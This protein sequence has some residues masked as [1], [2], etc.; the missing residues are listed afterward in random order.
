LQTRTR[1]FADAKFPLPHI[2]V[3]SSKESERPP[4]FL[5]AHFSQDFTAHGVSPVFFLD[6][7][8]SSLLESAVVLRA[9]A[10]KPMHDPM[11]AYSSTLGSHCCDPLLS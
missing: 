11:I 10:L 1:P 3:A 5:S 4:K 9:R 8:L 2:S 6:F 7:A